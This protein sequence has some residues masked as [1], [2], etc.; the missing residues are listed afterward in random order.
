M[1]AC[2][3]LYT[4]SEECIFTL[5][6]VIFY[7]HWGRYFIK[8]TVWFSTK[9]KYISSVC[10]I[11]LFAINVSND[12]SCFLKSI[13]LLHRLNIWPSTF[14]QHSWYR[15]ASKR[16]KHVRWNCRCMPSRADLAILWAKRWRSIVV[17]RTCSN[18]NLPRECAVLTLCCHWCP[19]A[20]ATARPLPPTFFASQNRTHI[21]TSPFRLSLYGHIAHINLNEIVSLTKCE[22]NV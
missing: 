8:S 13:L 15:F 22:R 4:V 7:R 21:Y 11:P 6:V 19:C 16:Y 14:E 18:A 9:N 5:N 17:L 20:Q 2:F 3:V 1:Y 12:P 10:L